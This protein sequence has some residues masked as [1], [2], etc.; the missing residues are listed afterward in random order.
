MNVVRLLDRRFPGD[1]RSLERRQSERRLLSSIERPEHDRR[2]YGEYRRAERRLY[3]D[4]R[5][6]QAQA[7]A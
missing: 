1:R 7:R 5:N 6:A 2:H 4:R 3:Q